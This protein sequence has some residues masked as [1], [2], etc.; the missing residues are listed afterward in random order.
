MIFKECTHNIARHSD[1][2]QTAAELK[3]QKKELILCVSD[4]G[5]GVCAENR[6]GTNGG[7]GLPSIRRRAESLNGSLD[8][9]AGN[10]AGVT[11]ALRTPLDRR[12]VAARR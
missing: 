5:S 4:N 9:I 11:L 2:T 6:T 3:I 10:G 7:H 1:C 8:F 12:H